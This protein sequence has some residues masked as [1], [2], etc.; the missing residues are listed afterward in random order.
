[1]GPILMVLQMMRRVQ[2]GAAVLMGRA[3]SVAEAGA[4]SVIQ[5]P[6]IKKPHRC[7]MPLYEGYGRAVDFGMHQMRQFAHLKLKVSAFSQRKFYLSR[8]H[9]RLLTETIR[10]GSK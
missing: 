6:I 3:K 9:T 7:L 2:C 10:H 8:T 1:M 5:T 4:L